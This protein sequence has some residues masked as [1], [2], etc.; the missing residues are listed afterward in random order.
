MNEC[1]TNDEQ[2]ACL[3]GSAAP[4][5]LV[6]AMTAE[7]YLVFCL[8]NHPVLNEVERT[9][10][11]MQICKISSRKLVCAP[12]IDKQILF[13]LS[14]N[15]ILTVEGDTRLTKKYPGNVA[16][17]V[18]TAGKLFFHHQKYTD[19]VLTKLLL[20]AGYTPVHVNQGYAACSSLSV[21]TAD[22]RTLVLTGD[23]GMRSACQAA[24]L[25][26][27][28]CEGVERIRLRGYD[29]GF[30]GGCCGASGQ[31]IYT[32]GCI[33]ETFLNAPDILHTLAE[34]GIRVVALGSGR[35]KDIG[36]MVLL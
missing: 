22:G 23:E 20:E 13:Q 27:V 17:N 6:K 24:G 18:L 10:A 12:S 31:T 7:G 21:E 32:C 28:W 11:D 16:Y 8:P 36:G 15:G 34:A 25:T 3:L 9:H 14:F 29:H 1:E 26:V 33:E 5:S 30:V 35:L 4:R 19:P 2:K